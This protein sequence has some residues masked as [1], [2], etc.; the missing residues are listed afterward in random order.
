MAGTPDDVLIAQFCAGE[1]DAFT[2]LYERYRDRVYRWALDE[3]WD[4][5]DAADAL[6]EVFVYLHRL[7]PRYEARGRLGALLF[8]VTRNVARSILR[9]RRTTRKIRDGWSPLPGPAEEL[10]VD[11]RIQRAVDGLPEILRDVVRL[12]ARDGLSLEEIAE[13]LEVPLGTVKSRLHA[14]LQKLRAS[15]GGVTT[16][17]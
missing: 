11:E 12:R 2:R 4:R 15:L 6:Q 10:P 5:D 13:A 8:R 9:K 17:A 7:A 3:L 14:A 1:A 16:D